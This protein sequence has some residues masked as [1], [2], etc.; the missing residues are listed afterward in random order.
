MSSMQSN[1]VESSL[2][3]KPNPSISL[4]LNDMKAVCEG[5]YNLG[6]LGLGGSVVAQV[7]SPSDND[8]SSSK[9][10]VPSLQISTDIISRQLGPI[11]NSDL[12][13]PPNLR[14]LPFPTLTTITTCKPNFSVTNIQFSGSASSQIIGL[15][16]KVIS[17][18]V[19]S[20]INEH[21][22]DSIKHRGERMLDG[23][24]YE[25]RKYLGGLIL[26]GTKPSSSALEDFTDRSVGDELEG[27]LPQSPSLLPINKLMKKKTNNTITWDKDMP[28][29]KS[30]LLNINSF[31]S[32]HLNQGMI[33]PLLQ[34]LTTWH[35][36]T[37]DDECKDCGFFFRGINGLIHSFTKHNE[38]NAVDI[39]I[40]SK[41]LN[42]HHNQ[43]FQI[44]SYGQVVVTVHELKTVGL[45]DLTELSLLQPRND[46]QLSSSITS[47]N[48]L[49][50]T[51]LIDIEVRPSNNDTTT[52][53][54]ISSDDILNETFELQFNTSN[55]NLTSLSEWIID[56]ELFNKL[57]VG[58]FI[59]G[60]Y[61]VF[62]NEK[63]ILNCIIEALTSVSLLDVVG[64][65]DVHA[66]TVTPVAYE[67]SNSNDSKSS[68]NLEDDIDE[69]INHLLELVLNEYS[70]TTTEALTAI[71]QT[72][73]K[74]TIN[75]GLSN[76]IGDTKKR[77]LHCVNV[78]IPTNKS[79]H[80]LRLDDTMA[81]VLFNELVNGGSTVD[82][83]N[84]FI[85]CVNTIMETKQLLD[86]HFYNFTLGEL[87]FVLHDLHLENVDSVGE[88]EVLKPEIDHYHL[89]NSLGYGMCSAPTE[90]GVEC[91]MTSF[92][93]G[94]NVGHKTN[95]YLGNINVQIHMQN[96]RLQGGTE[97]HFDM[98]YL[99]FVQITDLVK[100]PQ[101]LTIPITN[102]DFYGLN[103]TV[104]MLDVQIE[105]NLTGQNNGQKL[106]PQTYTYQTS[107]ISELA[108]T[109][110]TLTSKGVALLEE[111]L[112]DEFTMQLDKASSVCE[113][114]PNPRRHIDT[115]R[116]TGAA[117]LWTFLIILAF[118]V[119]NAWLFLRGFKNEEEPEEG[120]SQ[121]HDENDLNE[122]LLNDQ[123]DDEMN[124]NLQVETP[125]YKFPLT[126]STSLM[127][128]PSI[129]P[130]IKYGFPAVIA[131][132]FVLFLSSNLTIGASV[133]LLVTRANGSNLTSMV[134]IYA[135]SLGST[136]RE[137][138][139]AGVYLLMLLILFCS[140]VWPYV[141][142]VLLAVSWVVSTKKIPPVRREKILY[143]IDSLGK[144]S[145]IDA[146]V[147]VLMMVAFRYDLEVEGLG[148]LNVYVTPKYGFYSFL[149]AT[150][151]SLVSGHA[152]LF[153]HRRTM[154]PQIPVY[155]GRSEALA[156]HVFDD[157]HGRG[158]VK[159]T[160]GFRRLVA[161]IWALTFILISV[162]ISL[163]SFHFTI[164]GV[165]GTAL[166]SDRV[167]SY[168]LVSIGE[169]IP[170]SVLDSSSFGIYWIQTCY[171]FFALI[172]P[173][174]CL[175]SMFVL[176]FI[177]M[178]LRRQQ[179][180]FMIA[181][182]ANA[183]S[184]IEVFVI[185]IIAS[186]IEISPFSE[187]MVGKHCS[188]LN[189]ILGGWSGSDTN[190]ADDLH[191]CFDVKSSIGASS[192][193][194][195]IGVVLNSL[196]VSSLHRFAHHAIW[197]RIEREDRPDATDDE[198]RTVQECV[199]AHR[200]V[201]I[202]RKRPRLGKFIFEEVSFGVG[203]SEY[204]IDFNAVE[205]EDDNDEPHTSNNFW[206]EWSKIVSVI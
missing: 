68:S 76:L 31:L 114:P 8:D 73:I 173:M 72:P 44:G 75:D 102:F 85:T 205:D 196:L 80:P 22:C 21:V 101:C 176:F 178:K 105:V 84:T 136:M 78:D 188:L 202:L 77:P 151:V 23:L 185:A 97:L 145:L 197:E 69:L 100:H 183:W 74:T 6:G 66:M 160:K 148:A 90:G 165:A 89:S 16:S 24:F 122:P 7:G 179:K 132:A 175:L 130:V 177:P 15:F 155:S 135:F 64:R 60:S 94:M 58:S 29:L 161:F 26:N 9:G 125:R 86:G 54:I 137:M 138:A 120:Q 162:G 119:G 106:N 166:G 186:L 181:E 46:N 4:E 67:K 154:I 103:A 187:S 57:S 30:I 172:M 157:K 109:V 127:Y 126:S 43:T 191:Y 133:D 146:Y 149:F 199:L 95:G 141:K 50:I 163:K 5:M 91:D 65:M 104:D 171:F 13:A 107:D 81:I 71:I 56:G 124:G 92:S 167:R 55:V 194:L 82:I 36:G 52:S 1:Y 111:A 53:N 25:G 98:N 128:D 51:L 131:S 193:V 112:G 143:L 11:T 168:S 110:S 182:V 59:Y 49:N 121:L 134:N 32:Q 83:V 10:T 14:E 206:N 116:A 12:S 174:V 158:L 27:L 38:G 79:E 164:N 96:L 88:L 195:I 180:V 35:G 204:E 39:T 192:T 41:I 37:T 63:S 2:E 129:H 18:M 70:T 152:M 159:L 123:D 20:S 203:Y 144:F 48:G 117:G 184:A 147:L 142:L 113:T 140:G 115:K 47:T 118:L 34:K 93:F 19:T 99:P 153:L 40:P 62:D 190:V 3:D 198:N 28:F 108:A 150:I 33:L 156:R 45:N 61:S 200:F 201:S 189:Q 169:H 170:R 42:F 17:K 139:N 87:E